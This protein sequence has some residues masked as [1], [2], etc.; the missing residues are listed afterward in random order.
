ML[1]KPF[2]FK[3]K[4]IQKKVFFWILFFVVIKISPSL[5][6]FDACPPSRQILIFVTYAGLYE[7]KNKFEKAIEYYNEALSL[8]REFED[9]RWE[10]FV[11]TKIAKIYEKKRNFDEA[12]KYFEEAL[13][14]SLEE[15]DKALIYCN[16]AKIYLNRGNYQRAIEFLNMG[17]KIG[18]EVKDSQSMG[19]CMIT[20]GEIY[21]EIGNFQKAEVLLKEGLKKVLEAGDETYEAIVYENLGSLYL[22]IKNINL[23]KQYF[24]KAYHIYKS[25]GFKSKTKEILL[26]LKN[27]ENERS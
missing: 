10:T 14:A 24:I 3:W 13:E 1:I 4:R 5:A 15:K 6:Q 9:R 18:E 11:L 20:L 16:I 19:I 7:R 23:A 25:L 17:I 22:Y 8:T 12:L 27:I 2:G 26:I 21:K